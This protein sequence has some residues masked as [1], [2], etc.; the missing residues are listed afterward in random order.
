MSDEAENIRSLAERDAAAFSSKVSDLCR[1]IGLALPVA[2]FA[3]LTSKSTALVGLTE[4]YETYLVL[5]A[6]SGVFAIICDYAHYLCGWIAA[7]SAEIEKDGIGNMTTWGNRF[8]SAAF[9]M[10]WVKQVPTAL[11]AFMLIVPLSIH[12]IGSLLSGPDVC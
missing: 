8:H 3:L 6:I 7:H 2:V 12:F 1:Y 4:H 9:R 10:F 11:G 5:A